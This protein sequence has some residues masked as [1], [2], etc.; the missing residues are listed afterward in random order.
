[1]DEKSEKQ[2]SDLEI[3]A[4]LSRVRESLWELLPRCRVLSPCAA[5]QSRWAAK[6]AGVIAGI[7]ELH[8]DISD[9][10]R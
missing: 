9:N 1:M 6:M 4:E 5:L 2:R 3:T 8:S 10:R 7:D